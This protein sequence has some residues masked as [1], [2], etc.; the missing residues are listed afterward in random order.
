MDPTT[1]SG[2]GR[3]R[4][5]AIVPRLKYSQRGQ[6][7]LCNLQAALGIPLIDAEHLCEVLLHEI[8]DDL[9]FKH[10]D[11]L[12]ACL[13]PFIGMLSRR[14]WEKRAERGIPPEFAPD[15]LIVTVMRV[16]DFS[17]Y[18]DSE[19]AASNHD[20]DT[21]LRNPGWSTERFDPDATTLPYF[22]AAPLHVL[23]SPVDRS[24]AE[25]VRN[26]L[27]LVHHG[28][29]ACL[30]ALVLRVPD[31]QRWFRPTAVE[32]SPNARFLQVHPHE[33]ETRWGF[34][35]DLGK[36]DIHD[37]GTSIT[38]APEI[39]VDRVTLGHCKR[40]RFVALGPTAS[41]RATT[42]AD[43][44]FLQ[45][46]TNGRDIKEVYAALEHAIPRALRP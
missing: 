18:R 39:V 29:G 37:V 33:T 27:G 12:L 38:G 34:T 3:E 26:H 22:W 10:D 40:V 30:M 35:V 8:E 17:F 36:L 4:V 23:P 46:V 32:A 42:E 15:E 25:T 19:H 9:D 43:K 2:N 5:A 41:D 7:F 44:K 28:H 24:A 14:A 6:I 16:E 11:E 1:R 31:G 20:Y 13:K 21:G 45:H